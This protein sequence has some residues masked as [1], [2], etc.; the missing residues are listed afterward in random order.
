MLL[1]LQYSEPVFRPPSEARSLI[2]QATIGCSHNK[3]KFCGMYKM[4]DFRI[5]KFDDFRRDVDLV[6][7][8]YP[9]I[10]RVFLADGDALIIKTEQ[11]I[12]T[13]RYL[14]Q[15]FP[16]LDRVT[17]Y[18]NP[19]NILQKSIDELNTIRAEGLI[20]LYFGVE[21]GDD[22]L[23]ARV[24][25][26]AHRAE[27]VESGRKAIEAGFTLSTTVILGLGG[28]AGSERHARDT[29][30]ILNEIQPQYIGAL[31]LMLQGAEGY[32]AQEVGGNWEPLNQ[33]ELLNELR[34]LVAGLELKNSV[35]RSNHASNYLPLGG[36]FPQDKKKLLKT[37]DYA[38]DHPEILRPEYL[39]AL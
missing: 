28:K 13:L 30:T 34:I 24:D 18:A 35:F 16:R 7:G 5:R 37:I 3:C 10:R 6:A 4:K 11:M 27:I 17:A 21:S 25:K 14:Y 29:A 2:L 19:S 1:D 20:I 8:E 31:M 15:S 9:G 32:F 22:D 23:L 36:D 33:E 12:K 38:L 26:G 39:R